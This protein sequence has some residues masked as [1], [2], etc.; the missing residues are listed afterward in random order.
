MWF[1]QNKTEKNKHTKHP[2][3]PKKNPKTDKTHSEVELHLVEE[4]ASVI[5]TFL[6]IKIVTLNWA[7]KLWICCIAKA[8]V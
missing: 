4:A 8:I 3:P 6:C 5:S 2:T 7:R 1:L